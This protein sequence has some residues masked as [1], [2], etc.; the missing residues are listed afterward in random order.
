MNEKERLRLLEKLISDLQELAR[1]EVM[2]IVE[3]EKDRHSLRSLGVEGR[4][5]KAAYP[6]LLPLADRIAR[7]SVTVVL[8][9]DWDKR[10]ERLGLRISRYLKSLDVSID[11]DIR[12]RLRGLVGRDINDVESLYRY[13]ERLRRE[14]GIV[15]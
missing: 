1:S 7:E 9:T 6:P 5:V 13:V 2:I 4:I 12:S 10:G 15:P 8:L 11:T 3:G 14:C